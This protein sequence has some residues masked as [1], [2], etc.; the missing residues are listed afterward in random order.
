MIWLV[1]ELVQRPE[2]TSF[3]PRGCT[4]PTQ[5]CLKPRAY[6]W[7]LRLAFAATA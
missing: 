2:Q 1:R 6:A 5:N 7:S 3:A 4:Q